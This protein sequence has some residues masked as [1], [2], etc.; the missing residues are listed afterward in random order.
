MK[1]RNK[2]GYFWRIQKEL[3]KLA[4]KNRVFDTNQLGRF[5]KAKQ[6]YIILNSIN[7][8]I[9]FKQTKRKKK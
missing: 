4:N 2:C 7:F 5:T 1:R 9:I 8:N 6:K 3:K